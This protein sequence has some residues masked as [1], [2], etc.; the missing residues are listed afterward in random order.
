MNLKRNR[1][2]DNWGERES[3]RQVNYNHYQSSDV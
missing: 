1:I 2:T 3:G